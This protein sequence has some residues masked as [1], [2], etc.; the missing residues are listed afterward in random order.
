MKSETCNIIILELSFSFLCHI[1]VRLG[2]CC[3]KQIKK[4]PLTFWCQV[5]PFSKVQY[6]AQN[7]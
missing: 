4:F 2:Y 5:S 3:R 7:D 6:D 1:L